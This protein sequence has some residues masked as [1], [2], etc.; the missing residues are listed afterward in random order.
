MRAISDSR[1]EGN[2]TDFDCIFVVGSGIDNLY[3]F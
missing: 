1:V 3:L 2:G